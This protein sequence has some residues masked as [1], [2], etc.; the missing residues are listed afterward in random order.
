MPEDKTP[1]TTGKKRGPRK[2]K[3]EAEKR[4]AFAERGEAILK[5]LYRARE[6][7]EKLMNARVDKPSEK[8]AEAFRQATNEVL[9]QIQTALQPS[10]KGSTVVSLPRE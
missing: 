5:A 9:V 8:Q 3:T 6:K 2:T 7:V 1:K 10:E 4:E